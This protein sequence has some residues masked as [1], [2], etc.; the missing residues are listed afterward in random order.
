MSVL[1]SS[2]ESFRYCATGGRGMRWPPAVLAATDIWRCVTGER[3]SD[4]TSGTS[5][6]DASSCIALLYKAAT[7]LAQRVASLLSFLS[8]A[9]RRACVSMLST[10]REPRSASHSRQYQTQRLRSSRTNLP[11]LTLH[12]SSAESPSHIVSTLDLWEGVR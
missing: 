12:L 8:V 6:S 4:R 7:K 5:C 11:G 1:Q 3:T 9:R 2:R 10:H